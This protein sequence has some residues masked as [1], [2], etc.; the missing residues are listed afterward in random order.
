MGSG[1]VTCSLTRL[2]V[3]DHDECVMVD[4]SMCPL[5]PG[6]MFDESSAHSLHILRIVKGEYGDYGTLENYKEPDEK[7]MDTYRVFFLKEAWDKVVELYPRCLTEKEKKLVELNRS[8]Q[9]LL[10]WDHLSGID[11][12]EFDELKRTQNRMRYFGEF[13]E[14]WLSITHFMEETRLNFDS[15]FNGYTQINNLMA[16][17][18]LNNITRSIIGK[19]IVE[20]NEEGD[21]DF[22]PTNRDVFCYEINHSALQW[23]SKSYA[24]RTGVKY[25]KKQ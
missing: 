4:F 10:Y 7:W 25:F 5:T 2:P 8:G 16:H 9:G 11:L 15:W 24:E 22:D 18:D 20:Q 19:R 21:E 23:K 1:Y 6:E 13:V 14:E 17:L 12:L 3:V